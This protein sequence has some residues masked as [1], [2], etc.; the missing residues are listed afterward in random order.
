MYSIAVCFARVLT[1]TRSALIP[2]FR[3]L[4]RARTCFQTISLVKVVQTENHQFEQYLT[5]GGG[6]E[7]EVLSADNTSPSI[8]ITR[9]LPDASAL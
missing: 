8:Q 3:D 5:H 7:E 2:A 4:S 6:E 9:I 1:P